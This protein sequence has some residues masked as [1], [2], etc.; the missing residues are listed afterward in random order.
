VN[1]PPSSP[2]S[3][4]P[5]ILEPRDPRWFETEVQAHAPVLRSYLQRRFPQ[6]GDVDDV[7]QESLLRTWKA[8][9]AGRIRSARAFLF[10]A[11]RNAAF[12]LFRRRAVVPME[13]L[14][15]NLVASVRAEGADAADT[16]TLNQEM[17][18]LQAALAELP[19]R[20]RQIFVLRRIQGLSQKE[21]AARLSL[22]EGTVEKQMG[23][24]LKRCVAYLRSRGVEYPPK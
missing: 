14:T 17:E 20:C 1:L 22:A 8:G 11:A 21:I 23:I 12:D 4:N 19:D 13:P 7:V 16:A 9:A 10:T 5:A 2:A 24:A 15:E 18:L 6:L 3:P